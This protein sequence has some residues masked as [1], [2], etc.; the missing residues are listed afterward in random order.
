MT[1]WPSI[2][3]LFLYWSWTG[4]RSE[5]VHSLYSL[6]LQFIN[7]LIFC[8]RSLQTLPILITSLR[9]L[10]N[11][12]CLLCDLPQN[13]L[14]LLLFVRRS[15][16]ATARFLRNPSRAVNCFSGPLSFKNALCDRAH[17]PALFPNRHRP[18]PSS[19]KMLC[20]HL[21]VRVYIQLMCM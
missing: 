12:R 5:K 4:W 17:M 8:R 6:L 11:T 7:S 15:S 16:K 14:F 2:N 18:E 10:R 21:H 13:V 3:S 1:L 9:A 19:V 20:T